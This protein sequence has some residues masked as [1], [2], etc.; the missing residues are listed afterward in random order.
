MQFETEEH[1]NVIESEFIF[2]VHVHIQPQNQY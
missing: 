2:N 1:Q